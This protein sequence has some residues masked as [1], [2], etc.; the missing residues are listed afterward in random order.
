MADE[1]DQFQDVPQA[2]GR[3]F[4]E[5]RLAAANPN[6]PSWADVPRQAIENFP[7]SARQ[8]AENVV[9]PILHPIDTANAFKDLAVGVVSKIGGA[10][11]VDQDP[12]KK[13]SNEAV[14]DAVAQHFADRYGSVDGF[15][16]AIASDPVGV[17]GDVSMVLSGGGA[18]AARAPGIIG[19][20]GLVVQRAGSYADPV[21]NTARA[22][23]A[24]AGGVRT[25]VNNTLGVTTGAGTRPFQEAYNAGRAGNQAF[26]DNMRGAAPVADVVDMADTAVRQMGRDRGTAYNQQMAATRASPQMIDMQPI[27]QAL[28]AARNLAVYTSP[29][30]NAI[31]RNPDALNVHARITELINDFRRLPPNERTPEALD[32]LKQSLRDI[33]Q[34]TQQ[35]TSARAIADDMYGATRQEIVNQVPSYAAAMRDY[36]Q[37][38]DNIDEMRRTLSINDRAS[39]DTT[40]R[41]LQ[42]TMRNNVNTNYGQREVLLDQLAQYQPNLPPALAGQSLNAWAPRGLMRGAAGG[43]AVYGLMTSNPATLAAAPFTSPRLMGELMYG[44]GRGNQMLRDA[45]GSI[46]L[47]PEGVSNAALTGY[48]ASQFAPLNPMLQYR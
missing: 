35:G 48:A 2:T 12:S 21:M 7:K 45:A 22:V 13:A 43:G 29:T 25:A 38:S 30:G 10:I 20:T 27:G 32:A 24:T 6:G 1:W 34:E 4:A 18:A 5:P 28:D 14:V 41:K 44:A 37:A 47:T 40:L 26:V 31:V 11:G 46:N 23:Q 17:M 39:T 9:Q 15:K 33:R 8:F 3:S 19:Q 36:A 42:S 16:R